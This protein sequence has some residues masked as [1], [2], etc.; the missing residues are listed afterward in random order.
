MMTKFQEDFD[1]VIGEDF[2][3]LD[4]KAGEGLRLLCLG[5]WTKGVQ[6][7]MDA[8]RNGGEAALLQDIVREVVRGL[9][10]SESKDEH[11]QH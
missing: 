10:S 9:T 1:T 11:P 8:R 5:M 2:D 7:A 6:R 4:P 3:K